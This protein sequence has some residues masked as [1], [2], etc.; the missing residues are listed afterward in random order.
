MRPMTINHLVALLL[1]AVMPCWLQAEVSEA[2]IRSAAQAFMEQVQGKARPATWDHA[3]VQR[4]ESVITTEGKWHMCMLATTDGPA[5]YVLLSETAGGAVPV[6]YS[7]SK[8][9]L[10]SLKHLAVPAGAGVFEAAPQVEGLS[11]V[12]LVAI[13][14]LRDDRIRIT[15]LACCLAGMC[16]WVQEHHR[17]PFGRVLWDLSPW[18]EFNF[19]SSPFVAPAP[20]FAYDELASFIE[21]RR[22]LYLDPEL[23][24]PM[25]DPPPGSVPPH[26]IPRPGTTFRIK[27]HG[28]MYERITPIVQAHLMKD[29]S[30]QARRELMGDE[31]GYAG[32]VIPRP[33]S[34]GAKTAL[35]VES[36]LSRASNI[37]QALDDFARSRGLKPVWSYSSPKELTERMLPCVL[38]GPENQAVLVTGLSGDAGARWAVVAAPETARSVQRPREEVIA[39]LRAKFEAVRPEWFSKELPMFLKELPLPDEPELRARYEEFKRQAETQPSK[40]PK[41]KTVDASS[42]LPEMLALGGHMVRLDLF[43]GWRV[44]FVNVGQ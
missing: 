6:M 9:P 35:I 4:I 37:E 34:D 31:R 33:H 42:E 13:P 38:Q 19:D 39:E 29:L 5:G 2:Q 27:D 20:P 40:E 1:V 25:P 22:K 14:T 44:V 28:V 23:V 8:P 17:I 10:E 3:T 32:N 15:P 43:E 30:R 21:E 41:M 16:M 7:A 18:P 24:E 12:P 11:D 26:L 36:Y